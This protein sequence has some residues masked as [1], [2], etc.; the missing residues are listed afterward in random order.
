MFSQRYRDYHN[1]WIGEMQLL[2]NWFPQ[3]FKNSLLFWKNFS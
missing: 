2:R 3:Q 1:I